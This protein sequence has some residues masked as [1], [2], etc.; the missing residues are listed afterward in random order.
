M[1]SKTQI[2]RLP[3]VLTMIGCSK[4]TL[5]SW[6]RK[7]VFPAPLKI[8]PKATGWLLSEIEAWV[9]ARAN[10]RGAA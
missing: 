4:P 6:V 10:D 8:G 9:A 2:L 5:Y 3:S 7:G 1:T